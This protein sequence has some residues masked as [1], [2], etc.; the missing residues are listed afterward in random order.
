MAKRIYAI[1]I[2]RVLWSD[3][4]FQSIRLRHKLTQGGIGKKE[5]KYNIPDSKIT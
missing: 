3:L 5:P 4:C 2:V 1:L